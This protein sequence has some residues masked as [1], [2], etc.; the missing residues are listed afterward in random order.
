[1]KCSKAAKIIVS[2]S[3]CGVLAMPAFAAG[4]KSDAQKEKKELENQL[5][6]VKN[7]I[8]SIKTKTEDTSEYLKQ[9][10]IKTTELTKTLVSLDNQI[11]DKKKDLESN[12]QALEQA[13][14]A[15]QKQYEDMKKRIKFLYENGNDVYLEMLLDA[16]SFSDLL[17]KAD[18]VQE[19]SQYDRNMLT[20]YQNT[21]Q[22]IADKQT[23]IENEYK[24]IEALQ[25]ETEQKKESMEAVAEEKEKEIKEY[26][27][28]LK[29]SENLAQQVEDEINEQEQII[30]QLEA[31]EARKRKAAEEAA[32]AKAAAEAN[33]ANGNTST[34]QP[35]S[36]SVSASGFTWP[37]PG[38]TR[39]SSDYGYRIHPIAGIQKMHNGI[40][41]AAPTGTT[42]VAAASG[43]VS[44]ASYS[45]SMGNYVMINHGGSL[46]TVYMH[47][48]ALA[49][50]AGQTVKAGETIAYVGSTGNSTG[51]H[52]HFSVR[53]N[54]AYVNPWNYVSK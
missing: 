2:L 30:A 3:L 16:K 15:S 42:I 44:A 28:Q 37:C 20:E 52:L 13:Q 51:P 12:K 32:K 38:V 4:S 45:S 25:T 1:M 14:A 17:N 43:T 18:F 31:E 7:E 24:Q 26:Q 46:Y 53:L 34:S 23:Q 33:K 50:S 54:G 10:D 22:T 6:D 8:D 47:C 41:I 11:E 9:L 40:D 21:Q 48:S 5:E 36:N 49:V 27:S 29:Q 39:I 19:M 35:S